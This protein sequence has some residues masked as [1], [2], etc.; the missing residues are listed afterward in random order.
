MNPLIHAQPTR[1]A[2]IIVAATLSGCVSANHGAVVDRMLTSAH[3]EI[4]R[5]EPGLITDTHVEILR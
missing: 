2:T 4:E 1:V 5:L 3:N